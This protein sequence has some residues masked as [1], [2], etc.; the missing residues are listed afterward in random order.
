MNERIDD[1]CAGLKG[2]SDDAKA[3]FGNLSADQ[4]NWKPSETGWSIAQCFDHLISTHSLYFPLFSRLAGGDRRRSFLE[5]Y[6]PLSGFFGRFLVRSLDPKNQKKM[7]TTARG[8]PS[9]SELDA[10]IVD[11][12]V[13]HQAQMIEHLRKL[14]ADIDAAKFNI[15]SPMMGFVTYSLDDCFTVLD[16]HCRRHLGQAKRVIETEGFPA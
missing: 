11:R 2:S 7:K 16:V 4:L 3:A 8:K 14:P 1:V 12:F 15:T 13:E 5:K 9:A 10:E 6:S